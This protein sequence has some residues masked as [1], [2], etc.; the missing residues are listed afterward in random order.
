MGA[1]ALP[2][3]DEAMA[4]I[5]QRSKNARISASPQHFLGTATWNL[6]KR[7]FSVRLGAIVPR[8]RP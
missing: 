8:A 5:G 2:V 3:A 1:I 7:L 6:E 4:P